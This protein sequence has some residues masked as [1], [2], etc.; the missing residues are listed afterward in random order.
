MDRPGAQDNL[1]A[2]EGLPVPAG[3]GRDDAHG[4]QGP[5]AA[6]RVLR[7]KVKELFTVSFDTRPPVRVTNVGFHYSHRAPSCPTSVFSLRL[8]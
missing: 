3:E 4:T 2:G 8:S 1:V 7:C 6:S 5:A